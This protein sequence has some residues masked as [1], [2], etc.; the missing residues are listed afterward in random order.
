MTD[1]TQLLQ[2]LQELEE[3]DHNYM[4]VHPDAY[5]YLTVAPDAL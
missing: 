3:K 1:E 4:M 2:E 5:K